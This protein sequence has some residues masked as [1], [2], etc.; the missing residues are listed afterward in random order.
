MANLEGYWICTS[1][2][3]TDRDN[4]CPDD[5]GG[6]YPLTSVIYVAPNGTFSGTTAPS[7]TGNN[8]S[9]Y[10]VFQGP[11][12]QLPAKPI[13]PDEYWCHLKKCY[14]DAWNAT[15][16]FRKLRSRRRFS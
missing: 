13:Q 9:L 4:I 15:D 8:R 6:T 1:H 11:W 10:S 14:P 7:P 5:D 12:A 3:S 16:A 2:Y